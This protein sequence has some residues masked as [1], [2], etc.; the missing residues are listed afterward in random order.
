MGNKVSPRIWGRVRWKFVFKVIIFTHTNIL[1]L[2]S[3]SNDFTLWTRSSHRP[4][5]VQRNKKEINRLDCPCAGGQKKKLDMLVIHFTFKPAHNFFFIFVLLCIDIFIFF[6]RSNTC[7]MKPE[8]KRSLWEAANNF[9][10]QN[11]NLPYLCLLLTT[12]SGF[13]SS[14]KLANCYS[15]RQKTRRMH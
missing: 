11:H 3:A 9:F 2:L 15:K 14:C 8:K 10:S 13:F 7:L 12:W 4:H 1:F 5:F 6:F